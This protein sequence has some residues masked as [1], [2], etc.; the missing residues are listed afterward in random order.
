[1]YRETWAEVDLDAISSNIKLLKRV[2]EPSSQLM[3]IVKADAYGHGA[4]SVAT[5]AEQEGV[6]FFG[7]AT[8]DEACSLREQGITSKILVLGR[9]S[10]RHVNIAAQN[11][12]SLCCFQK[13]WLEET[14]RIL[15]GNLHLDVHIKVDTGMNRLGLL[16]D[17]TYELKSFIKTIKRYKNIKAE[18]IFTHF[19][20]SDEMNHD[21]VHI[22][23]N[24]FKE[25]LNLFHEEEIVPPF[26]HCANSAYTIRFPDKLFNLA[27]AGIA[28][29]G[30]QPSHDVKME[31]KMP[32]QEVF[33]LYSEVANVKKVKKGESV[34]YGRNH[35]MKENSY[36]ATIP[37]GYADGI[38]R[39]YGKLGGYVMIGGKKCNILANVCMDQ[40]MVECD[41]D[42]KVGDKVT[43]IGEGISIDKMAEILGTINYEVICMMG[44]RIPRIYNR[45]NEHELF[46]IDR[47]TAGVLL[48][49]RNEK[50]SLS[51]KGI[52]HP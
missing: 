10:P 21:F 19:A 2:I 5:L 47:K 29:Y 22:Q 28:V 7:V 38:K 24:R 37:I 40:L 48:Q 13:E 25:V 15:D 42:V 33:S 6:T 11:N 1:M 16:W 17:E 20:T 14:S 36:I 50:N 45:R 35:F 3:A 23:L 43:L 26:V 4:A 27:R 44:K 51:A 12:L 31:K 8:L 49:R 34:G 30:L 52:K 41:R 32:L 39:N 46:G 18:G 9:V